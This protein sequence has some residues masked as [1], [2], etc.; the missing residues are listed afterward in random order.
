MDKETKALID[1]YDN[2]IKDLNSSHK[3]VDL[4]SSNYITL[5]DLIDSKINSY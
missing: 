5:F 2:K 4:I 1:F 3:Q